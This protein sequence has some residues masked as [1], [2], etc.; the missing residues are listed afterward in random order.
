MTTPL[1]T[2][3]LSAVI[4]AMASPRVQFWILYGQY[5]IF[6]RHAVATYHA[7]AFL[8]HSTT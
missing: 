2:I 4:A 5:P 3:M 6:D 8:D 7:S 1:H